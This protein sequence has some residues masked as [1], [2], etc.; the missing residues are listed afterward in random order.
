MRKDQIY[1]EGF[2]GE[3]YLIYHDFDFQTHLYE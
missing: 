3:K 2:F 1:M